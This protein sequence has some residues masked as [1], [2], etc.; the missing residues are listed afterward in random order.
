MAENN[1][2]T[3]SNV[4]DSTSDDLGKLSDL[5]KAAFEKI[6]AE[7]GASTGGSAAPEEGEPAAT[8][9]E[10]VDAEPDRPQSVTDDNTDPPANAAQVDQTQAEEELSAEQQ[11]VLD[12]IMAEINGESAAADEAPADIQSE[13]NGDPPSTSG[14]SDPESSEPDLGDEGISL[15]D[16][17]T[18]LENLLG[19]HLEANTPPEPQP[20]QPE[21]P[22]DS[23]AK[24]SLKIEPDEPALLPERIENE[25][26]SVDQADAS[27][28]LPVKESQDRIE[29][30]P[31]EKSAPAPRQNASIQP[32]PAKRRFKAAHVTALL[33]AMVVVA[34]MGFFG[35]RGY[36]TR[37]QPQ[38][39]KVTPP[40]KSDAA[41]NSTVAKVALT[42]EEELNTTLVKAPT[43][44]PDA[45]QPLAA[46]QKRVT[47]GR[48]QVQ[49]K[50]AEIEQ[51][52]QYYESGINAD[53]AEI[54]KH[55]ASSEPPAFSTVI[56]DK[57]FEL[58]LKSIQRRKLYQSKLER[59]LQQLAAFSEELIYYDRVIGLYQLF[60]SNLTS[61]PVAATQHNAEAVLAAY[62][63]YIEQ[64][65][66]DE[67]EAVPPSLESIWQ[68]LGTDLRTK[69]E[70][71]AQLS[72]LNRAIGEELCRGDFSRA[73]QL[74]A[75][76]D[77]AARCLSQCKEKDLY[78]NSLR[79]LPPEIART[80]SQWPGEALGLNGL[81][82]I[83][84][85]TARQ[86]A[87]WPGKRLSLNGLS[88]LSPEATRQLS[89]WKGAHLEMIGL[90]SIGAW[91]NY[92]TR[93]YLSE[94]LRQLLE[95]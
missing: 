62:Q 20:P 22:A 31:A 18:E 47:E 13:A 92:N 58:E 35:L 21:P 10:P 88:E 84:A 66:I 52:V 51:L 34:A 42:V 5:E 45:F 75:L 76:N 85:E 72:P 1:E 80:L 4:D 9:T 81:T 63:G 60:N 91:Q 23:A 83:T 14:E 29:T 40:V 55:L 71:S 43:R 19:G 41:A 74:T 54:E 49:S 82:T 70:R 86:L 69:Q 95:Q 73:G 67:I 8:A 65:A 36:Q 79:E 89:R 32:S 93:L 77:E 37:F 11:A 12:Q 48:K 16:F 56:A 50:T 68:Q 61:L 17:D 46:L 38:S 90:G 27:E 87:L 6:M 57:R 59:P 39:T 24:T 94:Q 53:L 64:L 78:L 26:P 7:I 30:P 28:P 25:E 3:A 2:N 33:A 15:E 44:R